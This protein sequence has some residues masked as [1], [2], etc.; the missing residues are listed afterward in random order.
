MIDRR[1]MEG[2]PVPLPGGAAIGVLDT[3][4]RRALAASAYEERRRQ[5]QQAAEFFGAPALRDVTPQDL[6]RAQAGLPETTWRRA[7]HI[8][9]ENTRTLRAAEALRRGDGVEAGEL[10]NASHES[11]KSDYEVS[12]LEL[13]A[14]VSCSRRHQGCCGA[15]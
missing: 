8:V 15:R 5:C 7:R 11:L 6:D 10:M 4:T 12:S 2:S 1:S 13:D 14:I 3:G 9:S